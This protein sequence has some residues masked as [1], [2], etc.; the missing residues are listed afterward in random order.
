MLCEGRGHDSR[1]EVHQEYH[2]ALPSLNNGY[3]LFLPK[4]GICILFVSCVYVSNKGLQY[5]TK[6]NIHAASANLTKQPFLSGVQLFSS[7]N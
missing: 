2:H 3:K 7:V 6:F 1:K 4:G 5:N